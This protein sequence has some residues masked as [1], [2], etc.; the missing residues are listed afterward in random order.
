[1][2]AMLSA[3]LLVSLSVS[4]KRRI[5]D[6]GLMIAPPPYIA[7]IIASGNLLVP[8]TLRPRSSIIDSD[9][10]SRAGPTSTRTIA[11]SRTGARNTLNAGFDEPKR[12]FT[13]YVYDLVAGSKPRT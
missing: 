13:S 10:R 8:G 5:A 12:W 2:A 9:W 4:A 11:V 6:I 1:M 3:W 7:L